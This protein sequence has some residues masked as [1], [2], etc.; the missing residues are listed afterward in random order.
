[1]DTT[2]GPQPMDQGCDSIDEYL[3]CVGRGR[4]NAFGERYRKQ[5]RDERGTAEL[6]MLAAP[7]EEEYEDFRRAVEAMTPAEKTYAEQLNDEQIRQIARR[8]GANEANV[9]LFV[10]GYILAKKR[11]A[12]SR[13]KRCR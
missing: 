12:T 11:A 5:F 10:N 8:A 4:G 6:A 2:R 7:S 1:M 9:A 13:A 3:A